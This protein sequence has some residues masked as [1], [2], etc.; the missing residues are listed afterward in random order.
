[1]PSDAKVRKTNLCKRCWVR[2]YAIPILQ[3]VDRHR[4]FW[5]IERR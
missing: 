1:M 5:Q 3:G 4:R 2:E